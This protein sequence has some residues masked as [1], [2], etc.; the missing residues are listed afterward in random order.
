[1]K[2]L[3]Y[4]FIFFGSQLGSPFSYGGPPF[5]TDDPEPVGLNHWEYYLSS[6]DLFQPGFSTGT[7]PYFEINY[8]LIPNMQVHA[9]V[10]LNYNLILIGIFRYGYAYTEIGFKYRF[11]QSSDKSFQ[12]GIFPLFEVPTVKNGYFGNNRLQAYLPVWLQKSWG[13]LTTYGGGGYWINP[14]SG[15][16]N[17]MFT[18]WETQYDF[19]RYFTLGGEVF[20]KGP[21]TTDGK[22]FVGFNIGGFINFSERFHFI[23]SAGHSISGDHAFMAYAGFLVTI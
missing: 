9:E 7:L 22:S 12:A 21:S 15:N 5:D 16:K 6:Q 20:Y 18:G 4:I 13:K 1:V 2:R 10:P 19:S 17:W 14:G 23:Y 8:G 11:F 3:V